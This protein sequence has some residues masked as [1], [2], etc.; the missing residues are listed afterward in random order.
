MAFDIYLMLSFSIS[1]IY[2]ILKL[3][4]NDIKTT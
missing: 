3:F 4:N 2:L 1:I